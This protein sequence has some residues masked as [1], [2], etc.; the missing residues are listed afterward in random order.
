M[1]HN[2][3]RLHFHIF[4][5]D[6]RAALDGKDDL[7]DLRLFSLD[8]HGYRTISFVSY[9]SCA[10]IKICCMAGPVSEA[11][12]LYITMKYNVLPHDT[13]IFHG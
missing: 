1:L 6:I 8:F 3:D 10:A 4:D 5:P 12:S 9:P 2:R 11:Y 13:V 7:I